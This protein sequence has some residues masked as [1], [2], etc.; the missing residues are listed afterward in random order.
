VASARR[1]QPAPASHAVIKLRPES[2]R[3]EVEREE[4]WWRVRNP[5]AERLVRRFDLDNDEA[6]RY[7]QKRLIDL[8]VEDALLRAGALAGDEVHIGET[9]FDFVPESSIGAQP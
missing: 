6:V 9:A 4:G 7:V 3:V 5:A 2:Q 1:A 8:G